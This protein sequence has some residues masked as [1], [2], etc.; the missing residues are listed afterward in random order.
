M[1]GTVLH[2]SCTRL[3]FRIVAACTFFP[4]TF[5]KTVYVVVGHF[6]VNGRLIQRKEVNKPH[7]ET[8]HTSHTRLLN[9]IPSWMLQCCCTFLFLFINNP[10]R[11]KSGINKFNLSSSCN[12]RRD[13]ETMPTWWKGWH[14]KQQAKWS[15]QAAPSS[16]ATIQEPWQSG[17]RS[18]GTKSQ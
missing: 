9:M 11:S 4:T 12:I 5:L 7:P 14:F 15:T 18:R 8:A 17:C 1:S 3:S 2:W 13:M 16:R 6:K 10:W